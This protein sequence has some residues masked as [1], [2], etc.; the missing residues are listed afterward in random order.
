M[1]PVPLAALLLTG[2]SDLRRFENAI[3]IG[4]TERVASRLMAMRMPEA[5][6]NT[7]RSIA[8][9]NAQKKGYTPS[10]AH[11]TLL[12]WNLLMTHVPPTIGKTATVTT[13]YPIRWPIERIF[14]SW[15]SDLH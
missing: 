2:A 15:K 14:K 9:K 11:L 8:R 12:A 10:Q 13:V 3:V 1:E 7:R 4:A 5:G 6:V